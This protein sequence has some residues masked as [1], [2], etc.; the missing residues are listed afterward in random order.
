MRQYT[1]LSVDSVEEDMF[2]QAEDA[3]QTNAETSQCSYLARSEPTKPSAP[4][5]S[6]T[7]PEGREAAPNEETSNAVS[8]IDTKTSRRYFITPNQARFRAL[9]A[10]REANNCN[11]PGFP[12]RD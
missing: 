3:L 4:P 5:S 11:L 7:T 6:S 8:P 9:K 1:N 10:I 12:E 2:A